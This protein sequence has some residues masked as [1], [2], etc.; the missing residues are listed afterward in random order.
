MRI[1]A[2]V[3]P[4]SRVAGIETTEDGLIVRVCERAIDGA[5]NEACIRAL[6]EHF[7]L[8]PSRITLVRGARSRRKLFEI[9]D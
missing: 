7:K 4:G 8:A 5:A 6:A 2:T 1:A 3:K 9:A